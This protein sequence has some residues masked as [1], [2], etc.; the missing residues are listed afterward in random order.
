[1]KYPPVHYHDYLKIDQLLSAQSLK[2]VEYKKPAHDE[3][4]FIIVHQAYELWFK[5][6]LVELDSILDVFNQDFVAEEK[7]GLVQSRLTRV[8]TILKH[9][10]GQI[11]IMETMTPLDFLEFRE[12]LYPASGFQSFQFRLIETKLGLRIEDRL[13]YNNSPFYK[14]LTQE[15]Q[16]DMEMVLKLPSLFDGL[17]KWLERIPFLK[18]TGFDFWNS[19]QVAVQKLFNDDLQVV[20]THSHLSPD[21]KKRTQMMIEGSQKTFAALFNE[22]EF[23]KLQSENYFR[24]SYKAFHGALLISLYRHMPILQG[25]FQLLQSLMDID[26]ILTQ[27]RYRHALMAHR[28]L[29]QKIGTGG[30]SG[31]HYLKAAT[32]KHKIYQDLFNLST[33]LIPKSHLPPLPESLISQMTFKY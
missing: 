4:L 20:E 10:L 11:D 32:E 22:D 30:S 19:Y 28:M 12:F 24:L 26:E 8:V 3:M 18:A 21:E 27:W 17:E 5:Q 16:A 2:S 29:G 15:Q 14:S 25:P 6:I 31:H 33:F 23:K 13:A 1:M 9:T 7:M